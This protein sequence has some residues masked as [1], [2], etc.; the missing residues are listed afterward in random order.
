M[1]LTSV[2][3]GDDPI[4]AP[5]AEGRSELVGLALF[6]MKHRSLGS[7]SPWAPLLASLPQRTESPVLWDDAER[8]QFLRGS[9]VLE[10]SRAREAALTTEW[11]SILTSRN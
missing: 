1:A 3:V 6:L 2:D 9:P 4:L 8:A 10:E 7:T 5:L 11:E